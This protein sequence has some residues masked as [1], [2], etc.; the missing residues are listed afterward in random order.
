VWSDSQQP[1]QTSIGIIQIDKPLAHQNYFAG[2]RLFAKIVD[3][4]LSKSKQR[5]DLMISEVFSNL[6][7]SMIL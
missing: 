4:F 3:H 6:H 5:L 2:N 7:D 1:A